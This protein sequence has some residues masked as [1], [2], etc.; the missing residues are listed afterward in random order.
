M[1]FLAENGTLKDVCDEIEKEFHASVV[2]ISAGNLCL[3]MSYGSNKDR[4][5]RP[6]T[7]LLF[8]LSSKSDNADVNPNRGYVVMQAC[9]T[10]EDGTDVNIPAIKCILS[11]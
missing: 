9:C 3:F 7:Q 1:L 2:V 8:E 11:N 5:T 10:D 6:L 4:L